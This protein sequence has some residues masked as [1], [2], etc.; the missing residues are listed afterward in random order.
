[1]WAIHVQRNVKWRPE[2]GFCA[3]SCKDFEDSHHD[4]RSWWKYCYVLSVT[5]HWVYRC[6]FSRVFNI[7]YTLGF[8]TKYETRSRIRDKLCNLRLEGGLISQ[9]V[10]WSIRLNLMTL[11][12]HAWLMLQPVTSC[13][14][15]KFYCNSVD[16]LSLKHLQDYH[17]FFLD[18]FL[19]SKLP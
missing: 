4:Q 11:V 17:S 10:S 16:H 14:R 15:R 19:C 12:T 2:F 13:R 18:Y 7:A 8:T 1:M 6:K 5:N 3:S 9:F